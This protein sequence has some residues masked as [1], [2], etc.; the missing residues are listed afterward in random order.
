MN[1]DLDKPKRCSLR[2]AGYSYA[3]AGFYFV[4]ICIQNKLHLLGEVVDCEMR[5]N[6]AGAM[7]Q[8]WYA[9]LDSRFPDLKCHNQVVMPN[10]FHCII[11]LVGADPCVGPLPCVN[12]QNINGKHTVEKPVSSPLHRVLQ[13]F[14]TMT[15][16]EYIKQVKMNGWQQFSGRLWQRSYF[17]H[18]IRNEAVLLKI[19]DYISANPL[20]WAFDR[21]N[22]EAIEPEPLI[23][24]DWIQSL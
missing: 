8:K 1:T 17:E 23:D 16:N 7:V 13:W 9:K 12:P 19:D 18:I 6:E 10:H 5:M 14:K 21:E 3:S 20:R 2:I 15:T 22:A 24:K 4:T 11:Q